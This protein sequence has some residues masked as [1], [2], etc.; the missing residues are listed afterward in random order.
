MLLGPGAVSLQQLKLYLLR[1]CEL[2]GSAQMVNPP[3]RHEVGLA[4]VSNN[5]HARCIIIPSLPL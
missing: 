2:I 1:V 4:S 5:E 3:L